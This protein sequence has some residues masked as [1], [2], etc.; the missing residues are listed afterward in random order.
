MPKIEQDDLYL[1]VFPE[2]IEILKKF[3]A[4]F[5][6]IDKWNENRGGSV[7]CS[8]DS[9]IT[10]LKL[11][12]MPKIHHLPEEFS[13][14]KHLRYFEIRK[15]GLENPETLS[16][17]ASF[18]KLES[19]RIWCP[20]LSGLPKNLP[21]CSSL[22][23]LEIHVGI[24][25]E[26]PQN[27]GDLTNLES[28]GLD[29]YKGT[30]PSSIGNC[31]KLK[32]LK[33]DYCEFEKFPESI[34]N[35]HHF[36]SFYA[37]YCK[38]KTFPDSISGWTNLKE[39]RI[40][41]S[42][43][44]SLPNSFGCLKSLQKLVIDEC[45]L[46]TLPESFE[47]LD[48]LQSLRIEDCP[49]ESL[50]ESFGNLADLRNLWLRFT[51]LTTIPDSIGNLHKIAKIRISDSCITAIPDSIGNI[52]NIFELDLTQNYIS[53]IPASFRKFPKN[54]DFEIERNKLRSLYGIAEMIR[55]DNL[56]TICLLDEDLE[57]LPPTA[58]KLLFQNYDSDEIPEEIFLFRPHNPKDR[59]KY[60]DKASILKIEPNY[61]FEAWPNDLFKPSAPIWQ[62]YSLPL[63]KL[64]EKL[65]GNRSDLSS[66]EAERIVYECDERDVE[67]LKSKLPPED[68]FLET[69]VA[70]L[71]HLRMKP[72]KP[73]PKYPYLLKTVNN[74]KK[75]QNSE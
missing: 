39:I 53:R 66:E 14:L 38:F 71:H 1:D 40:Y 20:T 50:P 28:L 63:E 12:A 74:L 31:S 54:L 18:P 22:Q 75:M 68:P 58:K 57:L 47:G 16:A 21:K 60:L 29:F 62:Y 9:H 67:W 27:L 44:E 4:K 43:I 64:L 8:E 15:V 56:G 24:T 33:L 59:N 65:V 46:K 72:I 10:G 32:K 73:R 23:N 30:I 45:S 55:A 17:L 3:P 19:M 48:A 25:S 70:Y 5:R 26:L 36:E 61:D 49:L 7:Y 52:P 2:E 11:D 35:L 37:R 13:N 69:I 6:K 42:S 41:Q 51:K 34:G